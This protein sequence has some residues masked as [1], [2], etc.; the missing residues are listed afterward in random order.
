[1]FDA[2]EARKAVQ[3]VAERSIGPTTVQDLSAMLADATA[4]IAI[5]E[6]D[7]QNLDSRYKSEIEAAKGESAQA[8]HAVTLALQER[9][10][11]E[12]LEQQHAQIVSLAVAL[13]AAVDVI[14]GTRERIAELDS[15]LQAVTT[16]RL[17]AASAAENVRLRL[18]S[19]RNEIQRR[20]E[21]HTAILQKIADLG[22]WERIRG[23]TLA[24]EAV[25]GPH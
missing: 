19:E 25:R 6:A 17:D 14:E 5:I 3:R 18:L 22:W 9:D 21:A 13:D 15:K 23:V 2:D 20:D 16:E 12:A 24:R 1:M 11:A 8:S 4:H 10:A 7:L